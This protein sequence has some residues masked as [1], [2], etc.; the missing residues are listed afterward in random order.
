MGPYFM[1]LSNGFNSD[2]VLTRSVRDSAAAL[3]QSA[4]PMPGSR[5]QIRPEVSSYLAALEE[6]LP[7]LRIGVS[8]STPYGDAVGRNQ[9][10]SVDKVSH[11]LADMGHQVDEYA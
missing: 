6:K 10:A 9:A 11:L 3:D 7:K 4:G 1:E 2:H 5:Y 8:V